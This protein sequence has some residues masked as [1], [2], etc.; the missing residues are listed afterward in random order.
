MFSNHDFTK[1]ND[2]GDRGDVRKNRLNNSDQDQDKD[3]EDDG[4]EL[5]EESDI[6]VTNKKKV[7]F[8]DLTLEF[9][10]EMDDYLKDNDKSSI[11]AK[12]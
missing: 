5:R 10:K 4:F 2:Q 3:Q 7:E 1:P 9:E 8:S 11:K 6:I 12:V